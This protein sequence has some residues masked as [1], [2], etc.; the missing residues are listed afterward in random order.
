MP[1]VF[2]DP[3]HWRTRALEARALADKMAD[4]EGRSR[5][6]S[7]A[8]EYDR[9]ADRAT[10]RLRAIATPRMASTVKEPRDVAYWSLQ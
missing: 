8:Q 7:I 3:E 4:T 6:I 5:M 10:V 9:L 2:N 1:L